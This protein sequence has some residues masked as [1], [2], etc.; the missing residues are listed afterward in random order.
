MHAWCVCR[1]RKGESSQ[2]IRELL[3]ASSVEKKDYINHDA[4]YVHVRTFLEILAFAE[5]RFSSELNISD[6][7]LKTQK[8]NGPDKSVKKSKGLNNLGNTPGTF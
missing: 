6:L 7:Q 5:K 4:K 2:E 1:Q 8:F 3:E